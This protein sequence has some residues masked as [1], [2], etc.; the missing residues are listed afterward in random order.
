MIDGDRIFHWLI[1]AEDLWMSSVK[2]N[3]YKAWK[4]KT[5]QMI[6]L[7]LVRMEHELVHGS[8]DHYLFGGFNF[9]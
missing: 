6:H 1:L 7:L 8:L 9:R 4:T 2:I 5:F 3:Q